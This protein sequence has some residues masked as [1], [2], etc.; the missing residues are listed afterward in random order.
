MSFQTIPKIETPDTYLD[1]AFRQ[2]RNR[3]TAMRMKKPNKRPTTGEKKTSELAVFKSVNDYLSNTFD[4]ILNS[5]PQV[6]K[7]TDFYRELLI[8][9]L[10]VDEMKRCLGGLAWAKR[11]VER[12]WFNYSKKVHNSRDEEIIVTQRNSYYGR[13]ASIVKQ[14]SK[15]LL[16]LEA[17]R[18]KIKEFPVIKEGMKTVCIFGFPNVGK[19]TLLSKLTLSTP[20]IAAYPFTTK[21]INLG[22]ID[23]GM[24]RKIQLLDTPGTLNRF[25]KMND[26]ERQAYL[27]LKHVADVIVY[28]FDLT[29][30]SYPI[31]YQLQLYDS[32]KE[33]NKP[34]MIYYSK[35]DLLEKRSDR[36]EID[37][38]S[39]EHP[40][41]NDAKKLE[42]AIKELAK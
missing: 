32:L 16:F 37:E 38:F 1:I 3:G 23:A 22:Y 18:K 33:F 2:G 28:V 7:M 30:E 14:V 42:E 21:S 17:A 36:K 26:I 27:A 39:K 9:T 6:D 40:G 34:I 10:D 4:Q 13:I 20:E 19:T 5:F 25:E 8:C 31:D 35:S 12:F 24:K 11:N 41:Y 15:E 29:G